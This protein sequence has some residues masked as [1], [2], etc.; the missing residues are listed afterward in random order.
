[1]NIE[2]VD[3]KPVRVAARRYVG[4]YGEPLG[5]FW[6]NVVTPWLA[7]NG[8]VD[9]PR[10]GVPLDNP[11]STPPELCRYD[12]CVELPPGLP[13]GDATERTIPGG[14]Y[15][16]TRFKGTSAQIG[17]AWEGFVRGCLSS[18]MTGDSARFAFEHYPR[19]AT[20]DPKTG[21]FGCELCFPLAERS[22]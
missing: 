13:V 12:C 16:A 3:R 15:A 21:V 17:A 18:G 19:G 10:F 1:V 14:K 20:H 6:R 9:C 8:L 11:A 7:D 22:G 5:K 4:P 2:T